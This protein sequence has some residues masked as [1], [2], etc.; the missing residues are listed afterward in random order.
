MNGNFSVNVDELRDKH[1]KKCNIR[2]KIYENLLEKCYYRINNA[3]EIDKNYCIYS[4][5]EFILGMPA[6]N[7]AYCAAYIIYDLRRNGYTANFYNP[8]VIVAIWK[9]DPPA[10]LSNNK[11]TITFD[12]PKLI[13]TTKTLQIEQPKQFRSV[14][15]YKPS[16]NFLYR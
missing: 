12:K 10:Y 4:I 2:I 13:S 8:N 9:Y 15:D 3:A 1:K 16:G 7:L 11:K 6:Y 5:P 14:N